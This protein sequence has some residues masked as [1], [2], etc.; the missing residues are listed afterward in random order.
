M[1]RKERRYKSVRVVVRLQAGKVKGKANRG[2]AR[3]RETDDVQVAR[4]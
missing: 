1:S 2:D 3:V 4:R